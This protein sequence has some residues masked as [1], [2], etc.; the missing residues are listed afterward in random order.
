[1]FDKKDLKLLKKKGI[2]VETAKEQ[3]ERFKTGFPYVNIVAP[4]SPGN[5]IVN[6]SEKSVI[7]FGLSYDEFSGNI[8]TVKFVPASGAATRMFKDLLEF[9]NDKTADIKADHYRP[10]RVFFDNIKE[11]AFFDDLKRSCSQGVDFERDHKLVLTCLL[12]KRSMNYGNLPKGLI[13]FHKYDKEQRTAF[14]EHLSEGALYA[15]SGSNAYLHFTVPDAY[16]KKFEKHFKKIKSEYEKRYGLKFYVD[17]SVQKPSTDTIAVDMQNRPFRD[18]KGRILFRPGGHGAL[19]ENLNDIDADIIFVKNIDNVVPDRLKEDTVRYKK[20]LAGMLK[21][22]QDKI[23]EYIKK[24]EDGEDKDL[25]AEVVSFTETRLF[26]KH[27]NGFDKKSPNEKRLYLISKLNRPLRVCGMVK[28]EGEPGGGPFFVKDK[29]GFVS[30]Q[31]VES[32]QINPEQRD[33]MKKST[34]F[35][36]VDLVLGV[37]DYR[38]NKFDLTKYVDAEAGFITEKSKD[39]KPLKALELPGLWNGGMAYWNTVFAEVPVSTFNP[40]KTVNDLLRESHKA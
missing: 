28:N 26:Q 38:G 25:I 22:L 27:D 3:L 18:D 32:A 20:A 16:V 6:L 36:P 12:D 33:I 40:V 19:I 21:E 15:A 5:G 17:F 39:G 11:F 23:F 35:N 24:L 4:A 13:K 7:K 31:I 37:K 34:H 8:K 29:N 14:A 1:M 9:K 30:L 10:V 2:S